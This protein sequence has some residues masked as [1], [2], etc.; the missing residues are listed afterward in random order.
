MRTPRMQREQQARAGRAGIAPPHARL[1]ASLSPLRSKPLFGVNNDAFG[2][3]RPHMAAPAASTPGDDERASSSW[4]LACAGQGTGQVQVWDVRAPAPAGATPSAAQQ[5]QARPALVLPAPDVA[6]QAAGAQQQD[7]GQ[8]S[9][10][11]TCVRW[12]RRR[13]SAS[14]TTTDSNSLVAGYESGSLAWWDLRR[15][16]APACLVPRAH[17]DPVLCCSV[18]PPDAPAAAASE[19]V[20]ATGSADARV[21]TWAAPPS[22]SKGEAR[23]LADHALPQAAGVADLAWQAAGRAFAAGCW[24]GKV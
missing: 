8:G 3:C 24:D 19:A 20:V 5:W 22:S 17:K 23:A 12:A 16:Q 2:F 7:Q 9:G 15:L 13:S 11:V 6:Q 18:S 21:R 14:T 10:V 4:L 1:C